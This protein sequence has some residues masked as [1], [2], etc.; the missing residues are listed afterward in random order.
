MTD[1]TING[2]RS[3]FIAHSGWS[4]TVPTLNRFAERMIEHGNL[5]RA[6]A[7]CGISYDYASALR[8]KLRKLGMEL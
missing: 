7:E 3:Q 1:I 6:A 5:K 4:K 8:G 2:E